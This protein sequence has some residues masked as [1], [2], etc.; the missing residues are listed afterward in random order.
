[1]RMLRAC[2]A[3]MAYPAR[4]RAPEWMHPRCMRRSSSGCAA[5][6]ERAQQRE[7]DGSAASA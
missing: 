6:T 4:A 2:G 7:A 5:A 3:G 1:V